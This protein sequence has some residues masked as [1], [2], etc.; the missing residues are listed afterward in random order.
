[1]VAASWPFGALASPSSQ[2]IAIQLVSPNYFSELGI[3]LL[4]GQGLPGEDVV[5]DANTV[6]VLSYPYWRRAFHSDPRIL[7]Q[8]LKVNGT[9][10]TVSRR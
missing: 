5:P 1:M 7:G 6:A 3:S 10:F 4:V 9:A 2:R 8:S